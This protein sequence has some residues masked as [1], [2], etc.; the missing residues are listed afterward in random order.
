MNTPIR[1]FVRAYAASDAVRAHMP[2]HKGAPLLGCEPWDI[3]EIDGADDLSAPHGI[4]AESEANAGRLFGA[5]TLYSAEGSSLCV[6]AMLFLAA[7][8]HTAAAG[9]GARPL[10]VAG[11]NAHKTFINAC[12]L[13]D[14]DVRWLHPRAGDAY[15]ACTVTAADVAAAL[16]DGR[17]CAV[18]LTS[19]DYLGS[20]A[21]IPAVAAVC[22]A[23]GVPL[24]VDNAHGAYLKFL[25]GGS[26]HPI[27][28]GADLCCD[29]A[30]KTLPALTG[31]AYL[32]IRRDDGYGFASGARA[33]LGLF[34]STSP[35]YLILQSLDAVNP[36]LEGLPERL[37]AFIPLLDA[38]KARL[39]ERGWAL[40]GEE[41]LKLTLDPRPYGFTGDAL[42]AMLAARN[43]VCEFHDPDALVLMLTPE[44]GAAALE[45]IEAALLAV[46]RRTP[47]VCEAP[48]YHPLEQVLSPRA[49]RFAASESVPAARCAGRVLAAANVSCPPAVPIAMCGER[50]DEAAALR[51]VYYGVERCDVVKSNER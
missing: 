42:A 12:A 35:S 46:E 14:M 1:D 49:A 34:A 37:A 29:S 11:R 28:L 9:S 47:L 6:R 10:I 30:H 40:R 44:N 32:H 45:R 39:R 2:G 19:P 26:R 4:I 18:Y 50:L 23:R 31:A 22:R 8:R 43:I 51:M 13:I 48:A 16:A 5:T 3:T 15:H 27:D 20:L 33:A 41:P 24:L 38:L 17:P 36:L 21:D 25:P 7:Q